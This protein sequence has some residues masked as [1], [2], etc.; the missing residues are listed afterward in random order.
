MG[1]G[2]DEKNLSL[3]TVTCLID[4]TDQAASTS[5]YVDNQKLSTRLISRSCYNFS[6]ALKATMGRLLNVQHLQV[7]L[8]FFY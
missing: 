8:L 1:D 4:E 5:F 2:P 3:Y 6:L 7:S